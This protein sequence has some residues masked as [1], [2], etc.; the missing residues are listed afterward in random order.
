MS[1]RGCFAHTVGSIVEQI[2]S[3]VYGGECIW[4]FWDS[5]LV[6]TVGRWK[7]SLKE[8]RRPL[9]REVVGLGLVQLSSVFLGAFCLL[10]VLR[11]FV[12]SFPS[13]FCFDL[14]GDPLGAFAYP[15]EFSARLGQVFKA[16]GSH[17]FSTGDET[18]SHG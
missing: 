16:V 5:M 1:T 14:V 7:P 6:S 4:R 3:R 9:L 2:R 13:Y 15:A 17:I 10:S 8:A 11:S 12:C 18:C